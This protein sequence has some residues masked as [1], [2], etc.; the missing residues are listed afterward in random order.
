MGVCG[1]ANL[2]KLCSHRPPYSAGEWGAQREPLPSLESLGSVEGAGVE[3]MWVNPG[4]R[5]ISETSG[6]KGKLCG[7]GLQG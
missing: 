2:S 5:D 4:Q 1:G 3:Q 7:P 6:Q